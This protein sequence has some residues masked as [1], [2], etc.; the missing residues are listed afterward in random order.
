MSQEK[1]NRIYHIARDIVHGP[2]QLGGLNFKNL[3]TEN[4]VQKIELMLGH[5]PTHDSIRWHI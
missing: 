3:Y 2:S 5:L 1:W 4:G